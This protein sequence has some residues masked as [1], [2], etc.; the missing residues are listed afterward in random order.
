MDVNYF[1]VY[2]LNTILANHISDFYFCH[3]AF[4]KSQQKDLQNLTQEQRIAI[5]HELLRNIAVRNES[6][7]PEGG[8][9]A[10]TSRQHELVYLRQTSK[11]ILPFLLPNHVVKCRL[12]MELVEEIFVNK[13]LLKGLDILAEPDTFN[14]ILIKIFEAND[15]PA[16]AELTNPPDQAQVQVLKHWCLMNGCIFKTIKSPSLKEIFENNELLHHFIGYMNSIH[17]IAVLQLYLNLRDILRSHTGEMS[18]S[19]YSTCSAAS[20]PTS[21]Q[22]QELKMWCQNETNK[23]TLRAIAYDSE[24]TFHEVIHRALNEDS[25]DNSQENRYQALEKIH[26]EILNLIKEIYYSSFIKSE[27][28]YRNVIGLNKLMPKLKASVRNSE[29]TSLNSMNLGEARSENNL[30][31]DQDFEDLGY[32][33][34][35]STT[36]GQ[37]NSHP[38]DTADSL[39]G[40]EEYEEEGNDFRQQQAIRLDLINEIKDEILD[41]RVEAGS[42]VNGLSSGGGEGR[43]GDEA[44][45][46]DEDEANYAQEEIEANDLNLNNLRICIDDI[47][48]LTDKSNKTCFVFVIQVRGQIIYFKRISAFSSKIIF[49]IA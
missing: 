36:S 45:E 48:E 16:N 32:P 11:K 46:E 10:L 41:E 21:S 1:A 2:K 20:S 47:E 19:C 8:H 3:E 37:V 17:S 22:I 27:F 13:I 4:L 38:D 14:K 26:D 34:T 31:F 35:Y 44:E 18:S 49:L 43:V 30:V 15:Q 9:F 23:Q 28:M 29:T 12:S 39:N 24:Q 6:H 25:I 40:D 5:Q 33:T 7:S 42:M